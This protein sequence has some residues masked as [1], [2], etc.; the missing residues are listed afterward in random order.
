MLKTKSLTV[1]FY[2]NFLLLHQTPFC[3]A[4]VRR[5]GDG[6]H[7]VATVPIPQERKDMGYEDLSHSA[8][9]AVNAYE[10]K[11]S[12]KLAQELAINSDVV[13]LGAAPMRYIYERLK[14]NLL[15][16][17]YSE[18]YFKEGKIRLLDPRVAWFH[19]KNDFRY[20]SKNYYMLCAS[21]YTAPDCR[22][23]HAYP[24]KTYKWGYFPEVK[25][26]DNIETIIGLKQ[27]A[28]ILWVG[29]IIGLK[30][31]EAAVQMA[32]KLKQSGYPFELN[33]IGEGDKKPSLQKLIEAKGLSDSVHLHGFMSQGKVREWMEK[34]DIYLFTSDRNEG[35]GAVLNESMN[36][37]CAVVACQEIGS[38][39]YLIEDGV[40]GLTYNRHKKDDL[41]N[42]V[43]QLMDN[44]EQKHSMQRKAYETMC[45]T[46]N[47][48]VAAERLLHLIEGLRG[49]REAEYISGPCSR[50]C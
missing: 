15:T 38:V 22:F 7:F 30:H 34:S 47:A 23:I 48:D 28:T 12:E 11:E 16:F 50:D 13:I 17:R 14:K 5:I 20:R 35:W 4:M 1:T 49:D 29:R 41:Y 21:A 10:N 45:N 18:R 19:Y 39:P 8:T 42:K 3:E 44:E 37:A 46:W 26:Y 32:E 31:P 9:Y 24:N 36:S 25:K 2:S 27:P 33:I 43:K 6:F 40:N